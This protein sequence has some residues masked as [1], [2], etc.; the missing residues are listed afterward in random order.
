[1]YLN[2][3]VFKF[4]TINLTDRYKVLHLNS[5]NKCRGYKLKEIY[6]GKKKNPDDFS[7]S[8]I[9]YNSNKFYM[10]LKIMKTSV[11]ITENKV[12]VMEGDKLIVISSYKYCDYFC[13]TFCEKQR[14]KRRVLRL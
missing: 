4:N 7:Q 8:Q 9:E 12:Q 10:L 11:I 13:I 2:K 6:F 14:F 5:N 3:S 1:M